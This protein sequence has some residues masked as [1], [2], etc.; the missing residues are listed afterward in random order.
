[1]LARQEAQTRSHVE[2]MPL[3]PTTWRVC[4]GRYE[5][6]DLRRVVGY[7]QTIDDGYEMLWMRP[8]PGVVYR[9]PTMD[10]AVTAI[11]TRLELISEP[12]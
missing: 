6:G 5:D 9:Y 12:D 10:A 7:L 4:N 2:L 1:M 11:S 8:R 3:S